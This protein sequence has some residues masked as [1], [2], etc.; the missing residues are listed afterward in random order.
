MLPKWVSLMGSTSTIVSRLRPVEPVL[1]GGGQDRGGQ[2]L[3]HDDVDQQPQR[4]VTPFSY[5]GSPSSFDRRHALF[6][7]RRRKVQAFYKKGP[8]RKIWSNVQANML[9][10]SG[11]LG[12]LTGS[13]D[14]GGS[15]GLETCEVVGSEGR[16]VISNACERLTFLSPPLD[17]HR[18]L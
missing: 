2:H 12:H 4:V 8:G 9:F 13:Y 5:A 18:V 10:R 3:Q 6:L 11:A 14:A 15:Y 1:A 16:F 7:R 17:R